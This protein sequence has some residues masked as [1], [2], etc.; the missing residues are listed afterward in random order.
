MDDDDQLATP[1]A[2]ASQDKK[3]HRLTIDY[4]HRLTIDY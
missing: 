4:W 1:V 2:T 3:W